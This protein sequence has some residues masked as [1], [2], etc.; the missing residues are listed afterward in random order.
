MITRFNHDESAEN[1][2]P[3]VK[4]L[5]TLYWVLYDVCFEIVNMNSCLE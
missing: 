5:K 1:T 4:K 2:E 3:R